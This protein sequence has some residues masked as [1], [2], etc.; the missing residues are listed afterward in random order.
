MSV[1]AVARFANPTGVRGDATA[2]VAAT[3]QGFYGTTRKSSG[4]VTVQQNSAGLAA[5]STQFTLN[6]PGEW[7]IVAN[8]Q[9]AAASTIKLGRGG[10]AAGNIIAGSGSVV[11][12]NVTIQRTF[13]AG[14]V[15]LPQWVLGGALVNGDDLNFISFAYLG[16]V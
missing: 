9:A 6:A 12:P 15:I 2:F 10:T 14:D 5:A 8:G 3:V 4:L 1:L 13:D 11:N 16:A 7:L